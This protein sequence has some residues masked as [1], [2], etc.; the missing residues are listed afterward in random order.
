MV[1]TLQNDISAWDFLLSEDC[2]TAFNDALKESEIQD[3]NLSEI[4]QKRIDELN[5]EKITK[6]LKAFV[7]KDWKMQKTEIKKDI[8][9][10]TLTE[11][12]RKR[13]EELFENE[14]FKKFFNIKIQNL[15]FDIDF[16]NVKSILTERRSV[17]TGQGNLY[18]EK[19]YNI[20]SKNNNISLFDIIKEWEIYNVSEIYEIFTTAYYC[21]EILDSI[22]YEYSEVLSHLWIDKCDMNDKITFEKVIHYKNNSKQN[23]IKIFINK[24][25]NGDIFSYR[26]FYTWTDIY[27]DITTKDFLFS[28]LFYS[29]FK[30]VLNNNDYYEILLRLEKWLPL[31]EEEAEKINSLFKNEEFEKNFNAKISEIYIKDVNEEERE[32]ILE[33]LKLENIKSL[34]LQK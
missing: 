28:N 18:N 24:K 3:E 10:E 8:K 5:E 33:R 17:L 1:N 23:W 27:K 34:L 13:L 30:A 7:D 9:D 2:E 16:H 20:L 4:F 14:D 19:L 25:S 31:N 12:E 32:E 21:V 6:K 22:N 29:I 26:W 11:D 15:G